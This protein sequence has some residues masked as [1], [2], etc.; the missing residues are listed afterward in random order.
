MHCT[1]CRTGRE[2]VGI[3]GGHNVCDETEDAPM[4]SRPIDP[5]RP[6]GTPD[7]V[8]IT[9]E[10]RRPKLDPTLAIPVAVADHAPCV[11]RLVTIGDSL[12]AGFQSGAIYH[13]DL[14]W[15]ALVARELGWF[16]QLRFPTYDGYGGLPLNLE[17][18][19]RQL[20][21]Q[22]GDVGWQES[23]PALVWVNHYLNKVEQWWEVEAEPGYRPRP[24]LTHNLGVHGFKLRDASAR[25]LAEVEKALLVRRNQLFRPIP[26]RDIDRAARRMLANGRRDMAVLDVARA[27]SLEGDPGIEVL[28][29]AL[30]ANHALGSVVQLR[31]RWTDNRY[32]DNPDDGYT[33][34]TPSHFAAEWHEVIRRVEQ[35]QA[36]HVVLA[37]VP[38]VTIAPIAR[39]VA[40]G[41]RGASRYFP[42]YTRPWISDDDFDPDED[43]H[44]TGDQARAIDSAIDQYNTLIVDTVRQA[45]L[46][47][48]DWYLFDLCGLLDRLAYKRYL[49][50]PE[51]R[52][53]WW[54]DVGG[55]YPLP[56]PLADLDPVP[57]TRF[58]QSD[59]TGRSAGGLF[60]LDGVHPTTIAY[61]ICA[62]EF[63]KLLE[64]AGVTFFEADGQTP[65]RGPIDIDFAELMELDSLLRDPPRSLR[66]TV[67]VLGWLD[68]WIDA[69]RSVLS[70]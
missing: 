69:V 37:T 50:Q 63:I 15:P 33:V 12:T 7:E 46:R 59:G 35:I 21:W 58:I 61:G 68:D 67:Q 27:L 54:G 5:R 44:L 6:P 23:A 26:E 62:Q 64:T 49:H 38:H 51:A 66:H 31:Y 16:S 36:R 2:A 11:N 10:A 41:E 29:V 47:G 13:T 39:G 52:P 34:W 30:G 17:F 9:W 45:R 28:V 48:A 4:P 55:A 56:R 70:S 25:T 60:S 20:E 42:F 19:L 32:P 24:G 22:F 1:G 3:G 8:M 53:S 43:P 57:D 65:R 18:L 14:S 40:V